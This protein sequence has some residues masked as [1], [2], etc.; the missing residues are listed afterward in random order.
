[1]KRRDFLALAGA[2]LVPFSVPRTARGGSEFAVHF[3]RANPYEPLLRYV[4]PGSDEFKSEKAAVELEHRLEQMFQG[5]EAMPAKLEGWAG[6]LSQIRAARFYALP[7]NL[8][9]YEIKT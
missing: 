3:R 1:M 2:S 4:E 5:K 8:V 7:E 9:R 6:R